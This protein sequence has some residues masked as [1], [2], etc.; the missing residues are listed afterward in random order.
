MEW[1]NLDD[2]IN[3][4]SLIGA[5]VIILATL[6][7]VA[8][9]FSQMKV[10]KGQAELTAISWDG[11]GEYKNPVPIG[12]LVVF[13]IAVV[14]AIWY[15]LIGYPLNSYSQIGEYNK[16]T[17]LHNKKFEQQFRNLSQDDKI[18]MGENLFLVQCA[19][20]HGIT[21][22]GI[23]GKAQ[24]LELWGTEAA[25]EDVVRNGTKGNTPLSE[26]TTAK[27]MGLSEE[28]IKAVVAYVAQEISA[29]KKTKNPDLV[30][31]GA[32][33]YEEQCVAC[34]QADGTSRVEGSEPMAG[35]LT[36]YGAAGFVGDI[37]NIG[38]N[39][40]IGSMPKFDENILNDIQ[41]EAVSEYVISLS[42][43][44]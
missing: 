43:G 39:G 30:E 10:K 25:I 32:M 28:D 14:W 37:L 26:M 38:K 18:K 44:R 27:D 36:K 3:K 11:I 40:F 41:K 4:L 16:E 29:L 33:I 24:N 19:P 35:D 15:F 17:E 1:L 20:C 13:F 12:W 6:I 8:R 42:R 5:A 7:V 9:M 22:D 34:H 23:N 31:F 21:G 2:S